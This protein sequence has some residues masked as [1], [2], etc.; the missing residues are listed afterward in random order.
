MLATKAELDCL[1]A[2]LGKQYLDTR[3]GFECVYPTKVPARYA[4][5]KMSLPA[6]PGM[7]VFNFADQMRYL[8][9]V[10]SGQWVVQIDKFRVDERHC[11]GC[12]KIGRH[13]YYKYY[14]GQGTI[15]CLD[16]KEASLTSGG[17]GDDESELR[18]GLLF[19]AKICDVCKQMCCDH[20]YYN[21][22]YDVCNQ[23]ANLPP[24]KAMI[25]KLKLVANKHVS[26]AD[27]DHLAITSLLDWPVVGWFDAF[28]SFAPVYETGDDVDFGEVNC[29][30]VNQ[31][32][33]SKCFG[34]FGLRIVDQNHGETSYWTVPSITHLADYV[35][36]CPNDS[37]N[38]FGCTDA[39]ES[40]AEQCLH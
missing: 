37:T 32:P 17:G 6:M 18:Y 2:Q 5:M 10:V 11:S 12:N 33:D 29:L 1:V 22:E 23:C 8:M 31:N 38:T 24:G 35:N 21:S 9:S 20:A 28:D 14:T 25:D 26:F 34:M 36:D 3:S 16:C 27:F 30:L 19:N 13:K 7:K 39:L 15:H 4:E 40:Y